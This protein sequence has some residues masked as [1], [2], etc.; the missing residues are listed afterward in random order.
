MKKMMRL[1]EGKEAQRCCRDGDG[2]C[3]CIPHGEHFVCEP[4]VCCEFRCL[5]AK[6]CQPARPANSALLRIR[7]YCIPEEQVLFL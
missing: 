7:R 2:L 6:L 4:D 5:S 1:V 3:A